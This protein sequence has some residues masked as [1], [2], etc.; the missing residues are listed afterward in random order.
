MVGGGEGDEAVA[1]FLDLDR[2][3]DDDAVDARVGRDGEDVGRVHRRRLQEPVG[4]GGVA[5]E[6]RVVEGGAGLV[7]VEDHVAQ[8]DA[9]AGH[10]AAGAPGQFH[11]EGLGV[12][13]AEG[14]EDAALVE[15]RGDEFGGPPDGVDL[16]AADPLHGVGD[17]RQVGPGG[18]GRGRLGHSCS[19]DRL[20]R[21]CSGSSARRCACTARAVTSKASVVRSKVRWATAT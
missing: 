11:R 16:L 7:A 2:E 10:Q 19:L 14:L 18:G 1:A 4:D 15:A 6:E 17:Q 12:A 9:V 3:F 20:R 21:W 5:F 8:G 13:G